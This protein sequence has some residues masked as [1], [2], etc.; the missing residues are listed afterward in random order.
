MT[1]PALKPIL[2]A[3]KSK[4]SGTEAQIDKLEFTYDAQGNVETIKMY[5]NPSLKLTLTLAYDAN[6]RITSITRTDA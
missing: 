5:T 4:I 2:D 1:D 6:G 3:I